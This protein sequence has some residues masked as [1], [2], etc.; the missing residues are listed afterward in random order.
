V[1]GRGELTDAAYFC[2]TLLER[3]AGGRAEAAD[4]FAIHPTVLSK[5]GYLTS[6][7]VGDARG[8]RKVSRKSSMR[9]HTAMEL[10]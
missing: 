1:S 2:L 7:E 8:A 4:E 3:R 9:P 5:L 6:D 10:E